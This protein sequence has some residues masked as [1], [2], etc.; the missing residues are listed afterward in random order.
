MGK[1]G[2]GEVEHMD[3]VKVKTDVCYFSLQQHSETKS[4]LLFF[5]VYVWKNYKIKCEGGR[6]E[7]HCTECHRER[8]KWSL[9]LNSNAEMKAFMKVRHTPFNSRFKDP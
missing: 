2:D 3:A 8:T 6:V 7:G 5:H 9:V 1:E 4:K